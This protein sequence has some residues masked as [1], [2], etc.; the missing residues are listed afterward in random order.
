MEGLQYM[1]NEMK[2]FT[3]YAITKRWCGLKIQAE[4]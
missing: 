4:D 3:D 2:A 1:E